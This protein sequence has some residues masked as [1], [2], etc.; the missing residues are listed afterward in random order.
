[1]VQRQNTV[2]DS[3]QD[4]EDA[5]LSKRL[6][7]LTLQPVLLPVHMHIFLFGNFKLVNFIHGM[8]LMICQKK[9]EKKVLSIMKDPYAI[10]Y[11]TIQWKTDRVI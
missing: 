6:C 5:K 10:Y 2:C 3:H 9:K 1:M 7:H 8:H 4:H 11:I